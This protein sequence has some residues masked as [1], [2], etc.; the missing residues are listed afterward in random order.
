MTV[1]NSLQFSAGLGTANVGGLSGYNALTLTDLVNGPVSLNV[2]G[3][4]ASTT[5]GGAL[6]GSG[7]LTKIGAG[8]LTLLGSNTLPGN[9]TVTGGT[10][11][12]AG[13]SIASFFQYVGS[14]SNPAFVQSG[15]V[16]APGIVS[17]LFVGNSAARAEVTTSA[18][19]RWPCLPTRSADQAA[20]ASRSRAGRC[21]ECEPVPRRRHERQRH[22]HPQR[23]FLVVPERDGRQPRQRQLRTDRRD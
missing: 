21:A 1:D 10:L 4:G 22:V 17:Q 15:G 3:N 5:Y 14:T 16:N 18:A 12:L 11:Q 6:G 9:T 19:D 23:R 20:A 7:S 8:V 2:G 13:G